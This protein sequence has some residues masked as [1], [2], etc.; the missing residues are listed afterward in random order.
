[1]RRRDF[2]TFLASTPIAWSAFA[3]AQQRNEAIRVGWLSLSPA[4]R[5]NPVFA[6]FEQGMRDLGYTD[7]QNLIIE[8]RKADGNADR[9]PDL[10]AELVSLP[11]DVIIAVGAESVL[12]ATAQATDS[13]PIVMMAINYDPI[14]KRFIDNLARPGGNITGMFF[15]QSLL[16]GKRI[17]LLKAALPQLSRAVALYDRYSA[18]QLQSTAAAARSLGVALISI[19]LDKP[20]YDF[21]RAMRM[22]IEKQA[23]ALVVLS[24]PVFFGQRMQAAEATVR[25]RLPAIFQFGFYAKAGGLMAY[26][27]NLPDMFRYAATT[28][29]AKILRG[30]NPADL[31]VEQPTHFDLVV[32]L[33]TAATLG[34]NLPQAILFQATEVIE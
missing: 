34:L 22:A 33:K 24:S 25:H 17:E 19:E 8:F 5:G 28:Y 4:P 6:G 12:R 11:V 7:G 15:M 20:P 3:S 2:I 13:V 30:A 16:M 18:D 31:P 10:A 27:M 29:V 23:Q 9:L 14:A 21:D 1:M 26:G 32:N